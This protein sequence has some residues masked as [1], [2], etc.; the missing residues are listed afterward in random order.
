MPYSLLCQ[1]PR[2][3]NCSRVM[4]LHMLVCNKLDLKSDL[5]STLYESSRLLNGH[6]GVGTLYTTAPKTR[7]YAESTLT[8]GNKLY[9]A[10]RSSRL[11]RS[12]FGL[13]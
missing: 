13:L 2:V 3:L 4:C 10:D 5:I 11:Y 7:K 6:Y 12:V 8:R 9:P 1:D